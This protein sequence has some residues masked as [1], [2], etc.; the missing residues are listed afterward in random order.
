MIFQIGGKPSDGDQSMKEAKGS[1]AHSWQFRPERPADAPRIEALVAAS[2]GPGRHAKSAWRLREGV[3]PVAGLGFVAIEGGTLRGS[4]R[5]WPVV[6][7][8]A[9]ALL[10]GPLAVQ[11]DQRGR[12]I[13]IDLMN[14]GIE[15]ARK[16]G[17]KAM[18][19]VGDAPYYGRVGF[20]PIPRGRVRF[21]GP[22]D[23]ARILGLALEDG[24]LGALEGPVHRAQLDDPVCA[25]GAELG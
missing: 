19:L 1:T 11:T 21:P 22:V 6:I 9:R 4:V 5:F 13:G 17:W 20:A 2:F 25:D 10:L 8:R 23:P 15:D 16:A 18:I 14:R 7:G 3:A 24:A 12:G